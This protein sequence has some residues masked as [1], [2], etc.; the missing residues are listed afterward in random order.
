MARVRCRAST[1]SLSAIAQRR[2][3]SVCSSGDT[4]VPVSGPAWARSRVLTCSIDP[5]PSS[6]ARTV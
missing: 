4:G 3:R 6:K 5:T 1:S 2:G